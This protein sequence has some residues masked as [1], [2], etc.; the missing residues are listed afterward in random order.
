MIDKPRLLAIEPGIT[1]V[2]GYTYIGCPVY[3][4]KRSGVW[5]VCY[6]VL[7]GGK[8]FVGITASVSVNHVT[9]VRLFSGSTRKAAL[10]T[11]LGHCQ[12]EMDYYP[13]IKPARVKPNLPKVLSTKARRVY[14]K[15]YRAARCIDRLVYPEYHPVTPETKEIFYQALRSLIYRDAAYDPYENNNWLSMRL[16][17][18]Q[19]GID[20]RGRKS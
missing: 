7:G 17:E 15:G 1:R 9:S 11:Y 13:R 5:R 8:G 12:G 19:F 2:L 10:E 20:L 3:L 14:Q 18:R 4:V 16:Y 6:D